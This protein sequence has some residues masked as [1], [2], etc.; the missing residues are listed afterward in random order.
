MRFTIRSG[1]LTFSASHLPNHWKLVTATREVDP[2]RHTRSVARSFRALGAPLGST[3]NRSRLASCVSLSQPGPTKPRRL[4][5]SARSRVD[6]V[7]N[8][9]AAEGVVFAAKL[10]ETSTRIR[11]IRDSYVTPAVTPSDPPQ[12]FGPFVDVDG[13]LFSSSF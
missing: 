12:L 11:V 8:E 7:I 1:T 4:T 2:E 6:T 3:S 13:S 5:D 9:A 10:A